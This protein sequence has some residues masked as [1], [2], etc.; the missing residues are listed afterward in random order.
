MEENEYEFDAPIPGQSLTTEPGNRP[1][2]SPPQ[3]AQIEDVIEYYIDRMSDE[4][5]TEN[6]LAI[7]E[8]GTP[9]N[10]LV[11]SMITT[12]IMTG[13]HT[14]ESGLIAAPALSEYIKALAE[15][16][17]IEY[18]ESTEDLN[19]AP[20][21]AKARKVM[22]MIE[23]EIE[24]AQLAEAEKLSRGETTSDEET[25]V[26]AKPVE[27]EILKGLMAPRNNADADEAEPEMPEMQGSE[28]EEGGET[29]ELL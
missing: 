2:E 15:I 1:W 14:L 3:F 6:L 19:K 12:G 20:S 25:E 16:D 24:E 7:I 8:D 18:V 27:T 5:R 26:P 29:D 17:E 9:I 13:L 28:E 23:K 22:R 10:M 4:E 21:P 11:D